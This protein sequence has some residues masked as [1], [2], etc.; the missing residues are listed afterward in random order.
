MDILQVRL[1]LRLG[2]GLGF[3]L[4]VLCVKL[5]MNS[6]THQHELE[7][8]VLIEESPGE[9]AQEIGIDATFMDLIDDHMRVL[10]EDV[11]LVGA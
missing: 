7:M 2:L 3:S 9:E 8:R 10:I 6:S 4:E 5:C 1:G 11:L